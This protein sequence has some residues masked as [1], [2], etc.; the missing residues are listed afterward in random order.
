GPGLT[1]AGDDVLCGL[2]LARRALGG[3]ATER[4]LLAVVDGL[5]T[6][7][8]SLAFLRWSARGQQ[9]APLHD[10]LGAA[11]SGDPAAARDAAGRLAAFGATSG[12]AMAHGV[13]LALA[14]Y[15]AARRARPTPPAV[16]QPATT[17]STSETARSVFET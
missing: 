12:R 17:T 3:P 8:L 10:L 5:P 14:S 2:L 1:P 15:R 7:D 6:T 11:A 16:V 13:R 4:A 9:V